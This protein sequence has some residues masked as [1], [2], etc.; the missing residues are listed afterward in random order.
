MADKL[1]FGKCVCVVNTE[2]IKATRRVVVG[3]V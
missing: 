2:A 1:L 3:A